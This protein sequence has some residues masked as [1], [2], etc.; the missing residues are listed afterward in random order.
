MLLKVKQLNL[1]FRLGCFLFGLRW[2][3]VHNEKKL[4]LLVCLQFTCVHFQLYFEVDY[5]SFFKDVTKCWFEKVML[6]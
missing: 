5:V 3:K 6:C 1:I 4:M 2:K